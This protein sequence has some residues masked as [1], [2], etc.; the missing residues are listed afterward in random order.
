MSHSNFNPVLLL[1]LNPELS[2]D[3]N[4]IAVEQAHEMYHSSNV[5]GYWYTLDAIPPLFDEGVFISDNKNTSSISSL[6]RYIKYAM[7][8]DGETSE[9][10]ERNGRFFSTIYRQ[11]YLRGSNTFVFNLPGDLVPY[12]ISSSN[13]NVGDQVKLLKNG[14]EFH[15]GHVASI[16]GNESFT[17]CNELYAFSDESSSYLVYGIKLYDPIRLA[18][19][20]Y[21]RQYATLSTPPTTSYINMD[22]DFN[23]ELYSLLYPDAR[24]LDRE[25]AFV[26]YMNRR[27][28]E[29]W[30][31]ARTRDI[32]AMGFDTSNTSN[33]ADNFEYL[34]VNHHLD[35]NFGQNN[36]RVTWDGLNLF[37]ATT[38]D[39]R[40]AADIS[41]YFDGIITERAIKTYVDRPFLTTA[42]F[43]DLV[44]NGNATF[45]N[46]IRVPNIYSRSNYMSNVEA[47]NAQITNLVASNGVM[48]NLAVQADI[49]NYGCIFSG[50]IGITEMASFQHTNHR[51]ESNASFENVHIN[52]TLSVDGQVQIGTPSTTANVMLT[53]KGAVEAENFDTTSDGRLKDNIH[54]FTYSS[55]LTSRLERI[56]PCQFSY[57]NKHSRKKRIGFIAQNVESEFPEMISHIP[58]Y[59]I[60]INRNAFVLNSINDNE[61]ICMLKDHKFDTNDKLWI[62]KND[63]INIIEAMFHVSEVADKDTFVL[64]PQIQDTKVIT[65][66][67]Q[68]LNDVKMIDYNQMVAVLFAA[69]KG[70]SAQVK[71]LQRQS[72]E[73]LT[74]SPY[75]KDTCG[76]HL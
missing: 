52:H 76:P 42:N 8:N 13:L 22:T 44:V 57:K 59:N 31:I 51:H 67:Y 68:V 38:N 41:P 43:N 21:L 73:Q 32:N 33:A 55:D 28:N 53:I 12:K 18:K 10:V 63:G 48:S 7:I 19:V 56:N 23:F 26:D 39:V 66:Q 3:S 14:S 74:G 75:L 29:D 30:R 25:A 45:C 47:Q 46:T 50:C 60:P 16:I 61:T 9:Q 36:G 64:S 62:C 65:V 34:R 6:N 17:L 27:D 58:I 5:G 2:V 37:Y 71:L 20:S 1:Y 70:L 54:E 15:Y 35:L 11:A 69:V 49:E 40:K 24:L 72:N 4:V